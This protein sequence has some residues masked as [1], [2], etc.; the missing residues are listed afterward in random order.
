[1]NLSPT[2]FNSIG[3]VLGYL[4]CIHAGDR[5]YVF[6]ARARMLPWN[7]CNSMGLG[8]VI[9]ATPALEGLRM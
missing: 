5:M 8:C 7:A 3:S 9:L 6:L 4:K 1:M 2:F